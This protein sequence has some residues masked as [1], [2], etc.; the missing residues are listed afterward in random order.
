VN[1]TYKLMTDSCCDL[2]ERIT[3]KHGVRVFDLSVGTYMRRDGVRERNERIDVAEFY[4]SLRRGTL[5]FT[6]AVSEETFYGKMRDCL[7]SGRD[8]LYIGFASVLSATYRNACAAAAKLRDEFPDKKIICIDS[9][10]ASLGLGL[11]VY[12]AIRMKETGETVTAVAEKIKELVPHV[13]HWFTVDSTFLLKHGGRIS[14]TVGGLER[15]FMHM[16]PVMHVDDEGH[17][18]NVGRIRGRKAAIRALVEI[19]KKE[20]ENPGENIVMISH[21]DCYDDALELADMIKSQLAPREI[22]INTVNPVIGAHS[23]PGTLA[24][25]FIG[26]KR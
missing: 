15:P 23:G 12:Y 21:G 19:M 11:L 9:K 4:K 18:V 22:I 24:L 1:S 13:C 6:S 5:V 16:K 14:A 7:T 17:L 10:S 3:G 20:A 25:F 26:K 8:V 2:P